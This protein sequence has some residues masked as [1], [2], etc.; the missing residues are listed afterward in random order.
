MGTTTVIGR[1]GRAGG[2]ARAAI[3]FAAALAL[4][5]TA[6]GTAGAEG[7]GDKL[8]V[9][10]YFSLEFEKQFGDEG[11]GDPNGSFDADQVDLV[12][13]AL[14]TDRVRLAADFGWVH[15]T[16]TE[17][18]QGAAVLEYAF[19]EYTFADWLKARGGKMQTPFGLYNEI[20]NVKTLM[21]TVKEPYATTKN[22]S[23]GSEFRFFP[24]FGTGLALLGN[25]SVAGD[26]D[27]V[28]MVA[29]GE[30]IAGNPYEEDD[31]KTKS[32]T[33]RV[34]WSPAAGLDFGASFYTDT[35]SEYDDEGEPTGGET[36]LMSYGAYAK[37]ERGG[38]GIEVEGVSGTYEKS[39]DDEVARYGLTAMA[40]Y[41][42]AGRY[43]PY[44]RYEYLEP[45]TDVDDDQA[46]L[47][48]YG[49]N[50]QVSMGLVLKFEF[51]TVSAGENNDRFKGGNGDYTEFKAAVALAF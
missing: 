2:G 9:N 33:A 49:L 48:I 40:Y 14:P 31:N 47:Y 44:F 51:D 41:R 46:A 18:D 6:P 32:I 23:F 10:G 20:H 21:M 50:V 15:G 22:T 17:F 25:A 39:T 43:A 27:Y 37:Y 12:I 4:T 3:A 28:L 5:A 36:D 29:N 38:L 8:R 16:D 30:D 34:R 1:Q 7:F 42:I 19:A 13:N 24:R 35:L 26:L 45:D 11:K